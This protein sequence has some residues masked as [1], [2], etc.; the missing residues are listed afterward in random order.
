MI[1]IIRIT[2]GRFRILIVFVSFLAMI[3]RPTSILTV[4]SVATLM[5]RTII[6][7]IMLTSLV[8]STLVSLIVFSPI[9]PISSLWATSRI[10]ASLEFSFVTIWRFGQFFFRFQRSN[11]A[12][13]I[14]GFADNFA[15]R[16]HVP[17]NLRILGWLFLGPISAFEWGIDKSGN[18][19]CWLHGC[20]GLR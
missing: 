5:I 14:L 2:L 19:S 8:I 7:Y 13:L 10:L 11:F 3:G 4:V 20:N 6:W 16:W 12:E 15:V 17:D 1:V 18:Q 9:S